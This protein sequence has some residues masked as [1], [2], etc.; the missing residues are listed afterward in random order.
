MLALVL[1]E[2]DA[3]RACCFP[4][5]DQVGK[6]LELD[7]TELGVQ[8]IPWMVG[9]TGFDGREATAEFSFETIAR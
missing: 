7:A 9:G 4:I 2:G 8:V 6:A 1:E 3:N 5:K